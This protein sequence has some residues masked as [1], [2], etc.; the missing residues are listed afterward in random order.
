[1][2]RK[3]KIINNFSESVDF[4]GKEVK[5]GKIVAFPTDTVYGLGAEVSNDESIKKVYD[6][7]NRPYDSPLIVLIGEKS[8]LD[9]L[10]YVKNSKVDVLVEKFWPGGLTLILDKKDWV[11]S[12]IT[13]GGKTLGVR[14][15]DNDIARNLIVASGGALATPSANKS[16]QLSPVSAEHVVKQFEDHEIDYVI[17]GGKTAKAIESTILDMTKEP[18][19]ILRSGAVSKEDIEKYIGH[20]DEVENKKKADKQFQK[21]IVLLKKEDI[22]KLNS[23]ELVLLFKPIENKKFEKAE[24]LSEGGDYKEASKNLFES[25]YKLL[26]EPGDTIYVEELKEEGFGKVIMERIKKIAR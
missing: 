9:K 1:M 22:L 20:I 18:P 24:Y 12:R 2:G 15:P 21:N 25:L 4:I 23:N 10:V 5:E 7:K 13:S 16:G 6:V 14:M 17:D 26:E 19:L 8:F 3:M 11:S